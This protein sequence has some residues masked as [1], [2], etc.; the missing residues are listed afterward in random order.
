LGTYLGEATDEDDEAY[1][2]ATLRA[3]R[4][5]I[6]HLDTAINYRFQRSERAVGQALKDLIEEGDFSRQE[7]VVGTKGGFIPFESEQ[8]ENPMDYIRTE[9]IEPGVVMPDDFT[10]NGNCIAPD[11]LEHQLER[12]LGNLGLNCVDVYYVHNPE[13]QLAER[14]REAVLE[15]LTRSFE[16]LESLAEDGKLVQY[17]IATWNGLRLDPGEEEYLSLEDVA[18]CAREAGGTDNR[19]GAVQ[20]PLNLGMT[21][22]LTKGNQPIEGEP[23]TPL[24]ACRKLD[25]MVASSASILQGRLA[26]TLP[27]EIREDLEEFDSDALRALQFTRSA[28][29]VTSALV[30]MKTPEHLE[31]NLR[32]VSEPPYTEDEFTNRF[33]REIPES[34]TG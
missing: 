18:E 11:Y 4:N 6:N 1:R 16:R 15:E 31:E 20:L 21:E 33:L 9:F 26:R 22:A 8:P 14:P 30:G 3:V 5:G 24:E 28:P 19:F 13:T 27:D 34:E 2:T 25:L 32:L 23:L 10:S 29:G 12:S 17:G 7:I